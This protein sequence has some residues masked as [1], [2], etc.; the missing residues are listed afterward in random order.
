MIDQTTQQRLLRQAPRCCGGS[1]NLKT[2]IT[3]LNPAAGVTAWV[4]CSCGKVLVPRQTV[5]RAIEDE[6]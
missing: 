6:E 1:V 4:Q 3:S 5:P 2:E